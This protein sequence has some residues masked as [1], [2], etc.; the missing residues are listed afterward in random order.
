MSL[1]RIR[2]SL[3]DP[4][5]RCQWALIND[6]RD[7]VVGEGP[8]AALPRRA[9][10]VQWVI[11]AAQVLIT[12]A[13][14][15]QAARHHAGSVLAFAL[16]DQTVGEPDTCQVSWLGAVG[17]S[18][19]LA[20][21]DKPGLARW[22]AAIAAVGIHGHEVHGEA[23]LLPLARDEWSLAWNGSEGFVRN[24]EFEATATDCGDRET[25]PLALRLMLDEAQAQDAR[26][27]SIALYTTADDA[28]PD[29]AA[30]SRMLGVAVR[31]AG[32]WDWRSAPADAGIG[33]E[34]ERQ[35][36]RA[37]AGMAAR[38]RP[39]AWITGA[40]LLILAIALVIDWVSLANQQVALR[41]QMTARFRAVFPTAVA[42]VDPVLQMRRKLAEARHAAGQSDSSDF[43]PMIEQVA[44]ATR[45]LPAGTIHA[46]S[47]E[48]GRMTIEL[49]GLD[50]AGVRGVIE[51]LRQ[52]GLSVDPLP[53][54]RHAAGAAVVLTVRPS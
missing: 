53:A 50:E 46:V 38:L 51:R 25:P 13:R 32:S 26:P 12:R 28:L 35:R 33:L 10:R 20:L 36:W 16:E 11:P 14:V 21:V 5:L 31:P 47:Y 4:P 48:S 7:A 18:D 29:I 24:G 1:L 37:F 9:E 41:Q 23:L 39:A 3:S 43:L 30:W 44:A 2:V 54:S 17:E 22:D 52:S 27:L 42:V 15:P 40:A 8:L 19:V 45:T 49:A 6:G 34:Q